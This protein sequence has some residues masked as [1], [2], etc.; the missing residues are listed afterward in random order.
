MRAT[1][2]TDRATFGVV[3]PP[4]VARAGSEAVSGGSRAAQSPGLA[5]RRPLVFADASHGVDDDGAATPQHDAARGDP[6]RW[7]PTERAAARGDAT[8][9]AA[10]GR[11]AFRPDPAAR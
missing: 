8:E 7:D 10:A 5:R 2:V 4:S 3:V 1:L 11:D 9:R 6:A